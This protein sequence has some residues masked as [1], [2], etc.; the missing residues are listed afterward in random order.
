M[1]SESRSISPPIA[2][3]S[4]D[5]VIYL[6]KDSTSGVPSEYFGLFKI[7]CPARVFDLE[8]KC[9]VN[10]NVGALCVVENSRRKLNSKPQ[11]DV[12]TKRLIIIH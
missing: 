9:K 3:K 4:L 2:L 10:Q 8:Y 5:I 1:I 11:M 6:G 7:L 12:K